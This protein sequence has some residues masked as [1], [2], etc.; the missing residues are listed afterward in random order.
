MLNNSK[1]EVFNINPND[2]KSKLYKIKIYYN[3]NFLNYI[4]EIKDINVKNYYNLL[5]SIDEFQLNS[6]YQFIFLRINKLNKLNND[7]KL[8]KKNFKLDNSKDFN[9]ILKEY[10]NNNLLNSILI[11][12]SIQQYFI[13]IKYS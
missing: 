12:N 13:P 7:I 9:N 1:E 8:L 4:C 5:N 3:Y 11:M 2:L 10:I 6:L